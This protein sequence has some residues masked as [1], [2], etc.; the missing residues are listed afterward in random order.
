M[1]DA[2][3]I[4]DLIAKLKDLSSIILITK[5]LPVAGALMVILIIWTG[6][7]YITG[8]PK[9][10]ESAKKSFIAIFIGIAIIM[11]SAVIINTII[12]LF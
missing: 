6:I 10:E 9:A 12:N 1:P 11:L 4:I 5:I 7:K 8:G 2:D 3:P